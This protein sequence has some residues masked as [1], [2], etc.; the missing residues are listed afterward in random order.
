M[1]Q[2]LFDAV[3]EV[4]E[5][6]VEEPHL[7]LCLDFDGTLTHH[8][9]DPSQ[10]Q[11]SPQMERALLALGEHEDV[12]VAI[13][14]GRDRADLQARVGIPGLIFVGNHGL[15]ISGP[16]QL[17]IER[18]AAEHTEAVKK[19]AQE[20]TTRL[21]AIPGCSVEDKGLTV[22]VHHR[23]VPTEAWDEVRRLV[24]G[25][26]AGASHPFVLTAGEE[27]YEI[28]PRVYW[29]KGSAVG[30]IM[31]QLGK[32]DPLP[33][34]LGDDVTDEDAFKALADGITI[35]VGGSPETAAH[36]CL[37]GPAEVRKFLE[38]LH[39][40]LQHKAQHPEETSGPRFVCEA[41][42]V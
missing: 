27:A 8:V 37:E 28:R 32:P 15:E 14:G 39:D 23:Q 19:L 24:H 9:D 13:I 1:S 31:D 33:I 16:G 35:K 18:T 29:H 21:Q 10:A 2:P 41:A 11:L 3:R 26:L 36:Y 25:V 40:L 30:W 5:R 4:G 20:L 34:Y 22:A 12:T 38:W 42:P 6:I 7:L 17:F